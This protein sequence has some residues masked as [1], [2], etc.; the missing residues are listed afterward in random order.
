MIE[1]RPWQFQLYNIVEDALRADD[2]FEQVSPHVI[3][4]MLG[5]TELQVSN[6]D[7][8]TIEDRLVRNFWDRDRREK[9]TY[10]TKDGV[11]RGVMFA[12]L[13]DGKNAIVG[14]DH[15]S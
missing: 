1:L 10:W 7:R 12:D 3:A 11:Q 6:G 8:A 2:P 13:P 14:F 15:T 9:T 5:G 4:S